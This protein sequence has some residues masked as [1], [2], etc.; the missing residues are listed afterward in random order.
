ML[1]KRENVDEVNKKV[2][3]LVGRV[4]CVVFMGSFSGVSTSSATGH[5]ITVL[6]GLGGSKQG[7]LPLVCSLA[8][9]PSNPTE[10]TRKQPPPTFHSAALT[11]CETPPR[12]TARRLAHKSTPMPTS[13]I[14]AAQ[15]L[16]LRR[17]QPIM[18]QNNVLPA[19]SI[20][21]SSTQGRQSKPHPPGLRYI[22]V[23]LLTGQLGR[24]E[25]TRI[26]WPRAAF[27][28]LPLQLFSLAIFCA[29]T[30]QHGRHCWASSK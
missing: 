6:I 2:T 10:P 19:S 22:N 30:K 23:T 5:S 21:R 3:V 25:E 8:L 17:R 13:W 18:D 9:L 29:S 15:F 12:A 7:R 27:L 11:A 1:N 26:K 4:G 28:R 16:A 20:E 14:V 24:R